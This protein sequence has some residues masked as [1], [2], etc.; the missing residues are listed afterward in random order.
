MLKAFIWYEL[1]VKKKDW[2][3]GEKMPQMGFE[4]AH[5]DWH[6]LGDTELSHQTT[7][8]E[9]LLWLLCFD[10]DIFA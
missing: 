8:I 4:P 3:G 2:G 9:V 7:W 6:S 5:A 10:M 1:A